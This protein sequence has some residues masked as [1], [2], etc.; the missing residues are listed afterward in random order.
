INYTT[1]HAM[2]PNR[3]VPVPMESCWFEVELKYFGGRYLGSRGVLSPSQ[4]GLDLEAGTGLGVTDKMDNGFVADE[5]SS[6][7]VLGDEGEHS[8]F[9]LVPLAGSRGKVRHMNLQPG[10]IGQSLYADLPQLRTVAIAAAGI[11]HNQ[12]LR[13]SRIGLAP[14]VPPPG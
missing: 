5:W 14:H 13:G 3:V 12:Q 4:L 10:E 8:V 6:P 7:P 9:D 11:G 2:G 1:L